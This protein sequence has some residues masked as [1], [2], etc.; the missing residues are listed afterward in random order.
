MDIRVSGI[1][2]DILMM[3]VYL[4]RNAASPLIEKDLASGV[5]IKLKDKDLVSSAA[6]ALKGAP[7]VSRVT[8]RDDISI[9]VQ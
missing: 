5:F 1:V 8:I 6:S 9:G 7:A 4:D 3:M 2:Y